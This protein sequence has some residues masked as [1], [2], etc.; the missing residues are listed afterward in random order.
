MSI[1][2]QILLK[3]LIQFENDD[4]QSELRLTGLIVKNN[5]FLT[6]CNPIYEA[7]FDLDWLNHQLDNKRP[8]S[9]ALKAWL[10]SNREQVF[11]L[12]GKTLS[13]LDYQFLA[14]SQA[15]QDRKEIEF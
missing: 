9:N 15:E 6:V 10:H 5:N 1:Y 2:Q 8:Y 11:L 4:E 14:V 3:Q 13:N 7:V 12:Q